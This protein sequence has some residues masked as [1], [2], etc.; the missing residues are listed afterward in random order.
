MMY[1]EDKIDVSRETEQAE[2]EEEIA[3]DT[4]ILKRR[5]TTAI[6][7]VT[8]KRNELVTFMLNVD[9]LH[10]VKTHLAHTQETHTRLY[11]TLTQKAN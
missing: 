3:E 5:Q 11:D 9:N 7:K 10:V 6:D 4:T 8:R 1:F 2:L